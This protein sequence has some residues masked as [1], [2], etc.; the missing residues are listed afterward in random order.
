MKRPC[1][2]FGGPFSA[3]LSMQGIW[4]DLGLGGT[5][6][7]THHASAFPN[8]SQLFSFGIPTSCFCWEVWCQFLHASL[9]TP[10][11]GHK[12]WPLLVSLLV[13]QILF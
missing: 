1:N 2:R 4:R 9:S 13:L 6:P 11:N 10:V 7:Q 5:L 8:P 12:G 3:F